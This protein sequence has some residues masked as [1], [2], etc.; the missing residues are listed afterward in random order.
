MK[1]DK[2]PWEILFNGIGFEGWS[3][4]GSCGKAWV[5]DSTITTHIVNQTHE[6][7]FIQTNKAYTDF[8]LEADF[9]IDGRIHTGILIRAEPT[10]DT[11]KVCICGYQVKIDPTDR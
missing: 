6:H 10:S 3:I 7:T 2:E 8:I 1:I 5:E 4:M 9:K 11:T